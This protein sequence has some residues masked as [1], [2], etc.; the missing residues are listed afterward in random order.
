M[1]QNRCLTVPGAFWDGVQCVCHEGFNII[2]LGCFCEGVT[3][4]NFC[5]RCAHR[6][7]SEWKYGECQCKQGYTLFSGECLGNFEGKDQP[8]DCNVG[9]F[10]D[11]Q[12]KR[13]IAC[14]SGC[15]SCKNSY[16]CDLCK[17]EFSYEVSS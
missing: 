2:G 17:P 10:F 8:G 3:K 9:T 15:L 5:D 4:G 6:P 12:Q 11:D 16:S 13:C 14:P 1:N 7:N